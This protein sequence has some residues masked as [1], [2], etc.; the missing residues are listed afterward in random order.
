MRISVNIS[1]TADGKAGIPGKNKLDRMGNDADMRR[2]KRLREEADAIVVGSKTIEYDNVALGLRTDLMRRVGELVYPLRIAVLGRVTLPSADK[3]I[4]NPDKGGS[5][6]IACGNNQID[7]IKNRH[8]DIQVIACGQQ[9]WIDVKFLVD[10]LAGE[11]AVDNL[12]IEGG[13]SLIGSFLKEDLID[14]YYTTI[15]PYLFGG[16]KEV[17]L[18]PI[19]GWSVSHKE[20]R[21]FTLMDFVKSE[22]WIFLTYDRKR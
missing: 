9:D 11:F 6:I 21:G 22:D 20:D 10:K 2:M 16:R 18:S 1:M 4:F 17:S 19:E 7:A 12:L 5:T 14:R 3:N 15:C 13:P 8:K